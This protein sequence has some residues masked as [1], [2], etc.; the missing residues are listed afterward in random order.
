MLL[1][2]KRI[3]D[4]ENLS[5]VIIVAM[6]TDCDQI[7]IIYVVMHMHTHT[8]AFIRTCTVYTFIPDG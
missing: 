2:Y 6:G 3:V 1:V 8:D 7:S 4:Q 5:D